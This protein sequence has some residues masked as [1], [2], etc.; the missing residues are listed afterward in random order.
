MRGKARRTQPT[1]IAFQPC[2]DPIPRRAGPDPR[3]QRPAPARRGSRRAGSRA[4]RDGQ[5]G[6]LPGRRGR[7][8]AR[9]RHRGRP[10]GPGPAGKNQQ[11][12]NQQAQGQ[13]SQ[14]GRQLS[15]VIES[16]SPQWATPG[17]Q[18]DRD[19]HRQERHDDSSAGP[20]R[21]VALLAVPAQ[22]PDRA[23]LYAAGRYP[24]AATRWGCAVPLRRVIPPG[25]EV[26]WQATLQP[27]MVGMTTFGVY[28]LAA[29]VVNGVTGQTVG[30]EPDVPPVLAR[31]ERL[32][33]AAAAE[34][35]LDLAAHRSPLPGGL[36]GPVQQRPG[37]PPGRRRPAGQAA[38]RGRQLL[39]R[40]PPDLGHRPGAGPECAHHDHAGTRS[41]GSP[42]AT[43]PR[44]CRPARPP[45]PG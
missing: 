44:R 24:A 1:A 27:S 19:R 7:G 18:G 26:S 34:H 36:P 23:G 8:H 4:G 13:A 2:H 22:Q 45:R 29:Q 12:Q 16:V 31:P 20:V 41:T 5:A 32:V 40:C 28:P 14:P 37:R 3:L 17:Q 9:G 33:A 35:R 38:G 6:R 11:A 42:T 39:G 21:P 30:T 10:G 15:V 25:G 43:M